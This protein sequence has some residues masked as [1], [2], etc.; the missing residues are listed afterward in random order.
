LNYLNKKQKS[1]IL[2]CGYGK[3]YSVK[4][5]INIFKKIKKNSKVLIYKKRPG[6]IAQVYA[7]TKKFKKILNFQPK[8]ND[9]KKIILS[10]IKWEKKLKRN[11]IKV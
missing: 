11:F 1:F 2:N 5:I 4:S 6:D 8:Y 3:G 10:A 9:I 7:N